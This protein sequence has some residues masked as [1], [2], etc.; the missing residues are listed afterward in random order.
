MYKFKLKRKYVMKRPILNDYQT[1]TEEQF[2]QNYYE[3]DKGIYCRIQAFTMEGDIH[4][5]ETTEEAHE[6]VLSTVEQGFN[7]PDQS[8]DGTSFDGFGVTCRMRKTSYFKLDENIY[9]S[10]MTLV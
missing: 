1:L 5:V 4:S 10:Y 9:R 8:K 3:P 7:K 6:A 2:F